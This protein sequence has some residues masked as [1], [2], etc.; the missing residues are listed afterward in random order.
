M[1][2]THMAYRQMNHDR[3]TAQATAATFSG[4]GAF[5]NQRITRT[6]QVGLAGTAGWTLSFGS[7]T[8]PQPFDQHPVAEQPRYLFPGAPFLYSASRCA[9]EHTPRYCR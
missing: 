7:I 3:S 2:A 5:A 9:D 6:D 1:T 4:K 8:L